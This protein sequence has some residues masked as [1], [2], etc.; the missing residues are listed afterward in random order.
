M[1][2]NNDNR[3]SVSHPGELQRDAVGTGNREWAMPQWQ[4]DSHNRGL[5]FMAEHR[6]YFYPTIPFHADKQK[7]NCVPIWMDRDTIV[8]IAVDRTVSVAS[9]RRKK[10]LPCFCT[11]TCSVGLE[12][13][14]G[15]RQLS[16]VCSGAMPFLWPYLVLNIS[17]SYT[18]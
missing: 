15:D 16:V 5:A 1:K 2:I 13:S 6:A 7:V 14:G 10:C 18:S 8:C 4:L 9:L 17:L 11:L 3:L 12:G